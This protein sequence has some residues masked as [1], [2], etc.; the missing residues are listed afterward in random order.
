MSM[1]GCVCRPEC[2]GYARFA[3]GLSL[4]PCLTDHG[5]SAIIII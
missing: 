3:L 2:V 4:G 5:Y 1:I